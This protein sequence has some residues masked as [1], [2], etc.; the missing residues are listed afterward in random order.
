MPA[1]A[2]PVLIAYDGSSTARH[3]VRET[4][5]LL[6]PR[7]AL[8][9]TVWEPAL[10]YY[11]AD[12]SPAGPDISPIPVDLQR[13]RGIERELQ[14]E[15]QRAA[16]AG[17]ELATSVGLEAQALTVAD[18]ADVAEAIVEVA[19][20]QGAAAIVVGSRGLK[21]LR[22]RLEGSTSNAVLKLAPCPV[23]VVHDD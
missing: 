7:H 21:G 13:A 11:A 18:E 5:K 9:V 23:I 19:R 12:F 14:E 22:A 2:A 3:A 16:A 8:V 4:A 6:G 20:D 17:A 15:A 1:S 10:A